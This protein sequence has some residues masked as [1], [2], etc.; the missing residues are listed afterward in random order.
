MSIESA[1]KFVKRMQEDQTFAL[2]LKKL[3]GK[4]E[5]S[6]MIKQQG[7][8]FSKE[9]LIAAASELNAVDVVGGKCCGATC[10]SHSVPC[11]GQV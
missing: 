6:A 10:E 8:D 7:F 2:T 11:P 5:R 1:K 4:D 9:E 3:E